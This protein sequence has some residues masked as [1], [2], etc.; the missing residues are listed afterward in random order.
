M[1]AAGASRPEGAWLSSTLS[2]LSVSEPSSSHQQTQGNYGGFQQHQ[3]GISTST[4]ALEPQQQLGSAFS[5]VLDSLGARV[6][7][8]GHSMTYLPWWASIPATT[9]AVKGLLLPLSI[10]ARAASLNVVLLNSAFTQARLLAQSVKPADARALGYLALVRAIYTQL[11]LRHPAP[12][13]A[14]YISNMGMQAATFSLL[15]SSLNTMCASVWPGLDSEGIL[16]FKDLTN[17]PV[18][19][20]TLSTPCGTAG[21][22]LPLA[23]VL[24]YARTLSSSLAVRGAPGVNTA[25]Q[26]MM[27]PFYCVSLIQPHATLLFWASSLGAQLGL[28]GSRLGRPPLPVP[29][30]QQSSYPL[31]QPGSPSSSESNNGTL[32]HSERASEDKVAGMPLGQ[33]AGSRGM[34]GGQDA[35]HSVG[36]SASAA[37]QERGEGDPLE[38]LQLPITQDRSLLSGLGDYYAA[39]GHREAAAVCYGRAT[40]LARDSEDGPPRK[41][42]L[43]NLKLGLQQQFKEESQN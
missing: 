27:V 19:L 8:A 15:T 26:L 34:E 2:S 18:F 11:R 16:Y 29:A 36:I 20:E 24:L 1:Q 7:E 9:L 6:W 28:Q 23:L 35:R 37:P 32:P 17:P 38:A 41:E 40:K 5:L 12:S 25:L 14:W 3:R 43:E 22:V 4:P 42:A 30:A 31:L 33:G 21:A 10:K 39:R 13:M